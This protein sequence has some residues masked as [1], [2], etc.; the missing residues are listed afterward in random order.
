MLSALRARFTY[1]NVMATI[2][3]FVA[4]GGSGY[5]ASK[6]NGKNIKNKSISGTK[7]KNRTIASRKIK[8]STI[9]ALKGTTGATGAS[10]APGRNGDSAS[11]MLTGRITG[12]PATDP[13][14]TRFGS[15]S[16]A[17]AADPS[18]DGAM[19]SPASPV[20]AR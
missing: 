3:V 11:S 10:G 17:S 14:A 12:L 1:A 4:L 2:A 15:P 19:P 13:A 5:A 8:K 18:G 6:I 20:V 9:K 16:G 7:L